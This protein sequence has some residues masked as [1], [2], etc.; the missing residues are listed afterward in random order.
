MRQG[1]YRKLLDTSGLKT[2]FDYLDFWMSSVACL[3]SQEENDQE[4]VESVVLPEK[5][6]V[7]FLVC[8]HAD[9]S[10][11][12]QSDLST[13]ARE[14]FGSLQT[15]PYKIHL[16]DFFVVDNTMS[17]HGSECPEVVWLH[18]EVFAVSKALSQMKEAIPIKRLK[19]K[20]K[21]QVMR[22]GGKKWISCDAAKTIASKA[23]LLLILPNLIAH[24]LIFN[25][26]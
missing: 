10:Y 8:T 6:P 5:L 16:Y 18:Q 17:S 11:K 15:K 22:E 1:I 19:Y 7:V 14:L 9:S 24:C 2:N 12:S 4:N 23:Q 26:V 20:K 3:A 25:S 13:L 21:L